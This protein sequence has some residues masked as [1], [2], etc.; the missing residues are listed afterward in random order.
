MTL[1][2][3]AIWCPAEGRT[4]GAAVP[5]IAVARH[6]E[7]GSSWEFALR[8]PH[9]ALAGCLVGYCG[10]TEQT[11]EPLRRREVPNGQVTLIIGFGD[12]IEVVEMSS[13]PTPSPA[14]VT[15]FVAG[16]H[17]GYA[18]VDN[19]GRQRGMQID[20]T[21]LGAYR[22][23]GMPMEEIANQIVPL[24]ALHGRAVDEL[25]ERLA[26]AGGWEER[27]ALLDGLLLRWAD[28]G[29]EPDPAVT[30]AWRQLDRS[31]GQVQVGALADEIGWSRR[32][33]TVRFRREVGLGPK[34]TA[35]VLRFRR[36]VE[37]LRQRA[38]GVTITD[39]AM[40]CGYADHSHLIRE[41]QAL[42]GCTPSALLAAELP[43]SGGIAG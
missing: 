23:L 36:A 2:E 18:L 43:G 33:F 4:S 20:L 37:L 42:A 19:R 40:T 5:A 41:F 39:V 32:H 14:T 13:S 17:H 8:E 31:D 9:P 26:T 27:F 29:P 3:D 16:V 24:D 21:P 10:Y 6:D 11:A 30:W 12:P 38:P 22:L 34:S 35:R 7:P 25:T 15:S 1:A 28:G